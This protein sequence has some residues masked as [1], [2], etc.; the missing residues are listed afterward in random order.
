VDSK[1]TPYSDTS[2]LN[3]IEQKWKVKTIHVVWEWEDLKLTLTLIL[4]VTLVWTSCTSISFLC[5]CTLIYN[6]QNSADL[7]TYGETTLCQQDTM[8]SQGTENNVHPFSTFD[9]WLFTRN[10]LTAVG[11]SQ[12]TTLPWCQCETR[13][14]KNVSNWKGLS[15]RRLS[16]CNSISWKS[17]NKGKHHYPAS[18][19]NVD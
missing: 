12:Q 18:F 8:Y 14:Q 1:A 16:S 15:G 13:E 19:N 3:Q 9:L 6:Y 11:V 4:T 2:Q 10:I 5:A 17:K 7:H